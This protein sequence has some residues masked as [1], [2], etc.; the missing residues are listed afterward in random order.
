MVD[1]EGHKLSF[2]VLKTD[3]GLIGPIQFRLD[4]QETVDLGIMG[5]DSHWSIQEFE[6]EK[7]DH[8]FVSSDFLTDHL[9]HLCMEAVLRKMANTGNE[10][11]TITIES[12]TK[13][14]VE[15]VREGVEIEYQRTLTKHGWVEH[16][17]RP[18]VIKDKKGNEWRIK[19]SEFPLVR[20][21]FAL[22]ADPGMVEEAKK[23]IFEKAKGN[24]VG[25]LVEASPYTE[26][27]MTMIDLRF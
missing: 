24:V 27:N 25:Y 21:Y 8:L 18:V 3:K 15:A 19:E 22:Q 1:L 11:V 10:G 26:D 23:T 6:L 9:D 14:K 2:H 13:V 4:T 17:F 16:D 7:G 20:Q 5:G 12:P